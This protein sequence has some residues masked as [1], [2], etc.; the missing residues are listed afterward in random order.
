MVKPTREGPTTRSLRLGWLEINWRRGGPSAQ[1]GGLLMWLKGSEKEDRW[2]GWINCPHTR[3]ET[4]LT[5]DERAMK[6]GRRG[7]R[8]NAFP[9]RLGHAAD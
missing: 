2:E 8:R 7:K 4:G 3:A 5:G 9:P 6:R 1:A